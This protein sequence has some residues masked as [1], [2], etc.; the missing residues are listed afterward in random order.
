MDTRSAF[1]LPRYLAVLPLFQEMTPPELER[2]AAGCRL[3]R[4]GQLLA[5]RAVN[6]AVEVRAQRIH[7]ADVIAVVVGQ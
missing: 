1:D 7:A 3:R 5:A 2:L 4:L 6:G